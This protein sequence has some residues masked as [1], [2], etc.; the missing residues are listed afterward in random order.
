MICPKTCCA[1]FLQNIESIKS[2]FNVFDFIRFI[3]QNAANENNNEIYVKISR[4]NM[5]EFSG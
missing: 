5:P 4:H 2:G 1:I 3:F